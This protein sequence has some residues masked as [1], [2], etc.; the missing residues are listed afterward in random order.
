MFRR[1]V[2]NVQETGDI[3][4]PG[5]DGKEIWRWILIL[6]ACHTFAL[7]EKLLHLRMCGIF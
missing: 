4:E 3:G 1:E 7:L 6:E 2:G 5:I